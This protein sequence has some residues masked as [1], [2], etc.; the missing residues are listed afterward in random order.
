MNFKSED[1]TA[2]IGLVKGL[3]DI[4]KELKSFRGSKSGVTETTA[5][6]KLDLDKLSQLQETLIEIIGLQ[7]N[8]I[9]C[10]RLVPAVPADWGRVFLPIALTH[11][12][13]TVRG[14]GPHKNVT[15]GAW[16][17]E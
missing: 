9:K 4:A 8:S 17:T 6:Q 2:A 10:F 15:R 3:V 1:M 14:R 11:G 5:I 7:C 12:L 13:L 16:G